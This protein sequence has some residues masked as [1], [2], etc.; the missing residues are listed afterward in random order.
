LEGY[1][2]G[3]NPRPRGK[4]PDLIRTKLYYENNDMQRPGWNLRSE[5]DNGGSWNEMV[6]TM[7]KHV[8]EKH[9]DVAKQMERM[10]NED[11]RKWGGE[12]KPKWDA[13]PEL[14]RGD[15]RGE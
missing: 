5:A 7:T 10:H 15:G 13:A 8:T 12:M 9:S 4:L 3:E 14:R 1:W 2:Y 11:P 6:K